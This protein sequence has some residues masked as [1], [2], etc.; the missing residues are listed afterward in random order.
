MGS[1]SGT[2]YANGMMPMVAGGKNI[3]G[4]T[5]NNFKMPNQQYKNVGKNFP[6]T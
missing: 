6:H 1:V 2:N 5:N 4:A 3:Q